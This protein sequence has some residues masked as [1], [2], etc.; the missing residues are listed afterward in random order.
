MKPVYRDVLRHAVNVAWNDK[1]S[2]ILSLL[3]GI[4]LTAS[5]YDVLWNALRGITDQGSSLTTPGAAFMAAIQ[6]LGAS[7]YDRT[8]AVIGGV[9]M[10]LAIALVILAVLGLSCIA[11]GA[12][13]HALGARRRGR[14]ATLS[15][16][17]RVGAGAF[18]PLAALNACT[19]ASLWILR[20]LP[21]LPLSFAIQEQSTVS[22]IVYMISFIIFVALAF[23]VVILHIF[24]L[25]AMIL[26]GASLGEGF[27]RGYELWK[28]H[29]VVVVETAVMQAA[30]AVGI[31]FLFV[32]VLML[33]MIPII[34]LIIVSGIVQSAG[35]FTLTLFLAIMLFLF[36]L[37]PTAAFTIQLQYAVWTFLYR[38]LGEG[39]VVPKL[40]RVFRGLTHSYK[41]PT[42]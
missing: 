29:W 34:A 18:W 22:Y 21:S 33:S 2:W 4:L 25:N 32:L 26:Q 6:R 5:S 41:V 20:L 1:R 37:I 9:E 39:G 23:F 10:L 38:R 24:A 19:A 8:I 7:G 36:E 35:L 28:K 12:L 15:E 27:R 42:N 13:V 14:V 3:A 11:Q 30:I 40:H 31:W 17:F 16:S